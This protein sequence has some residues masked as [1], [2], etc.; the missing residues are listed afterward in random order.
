MVMI[1]SN[2]AILCF[3][4]LVFIYKINVRPRSI[5][6][7]RKKTNNRIPYLLYV[8][9]DSNRK[10]TI[11]E[12]LRDSPTLRHGLPAISM[13]SDLTGCSRPVAEKMAEYVI[14][15]KIMTMKQILIIGYESERRCF[16]EFISLK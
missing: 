2:M 13:H 3:G 12:K 4:K 1:T 8:L 16:V 6:C 9:A 5:I 15:P 7:P 10:R 11:S 14:I